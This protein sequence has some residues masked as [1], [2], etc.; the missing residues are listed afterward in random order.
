VQEE[1]IGIARF[2]R[3]PAPRQKAMT[4]KLLASRG[5]DAVLKMIF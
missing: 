1:L 3:S 5:A 4:C 2:T